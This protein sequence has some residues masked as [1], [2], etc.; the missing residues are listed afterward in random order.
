MPAPIHV[1]DSHT[2]GEP[3]RV[4]IE[5]MPPILGEDM[6]AVRATL[7]SDHDLLRKS[8]VGEPRSSDVVVGAYLWPPT[9]DDR[10]WRVVFFNNVGYL[11][12]CGHGTIGVVETLRHRRLVD[13][14]RVDLVTPVGPVTT[15]LHPD[16]Q[17]SFVNVPCRRSG[18]GVTVEVPGYGVVRGDVAWGGN[19]FF[20]IGD[21]PI[22]VAKEHI[23]ELQA[24]T[25][26]VRKVLGETGVTGDDGGE[27]DHVEVFGPS[28]SAHSRNYVLCPGLEHDRS[29]C[30]TGTSAKIACLAAD[31]K[32]APGQ[33]WTQE[34]IIGSIF[35]ATYH[36]IDGQVVPTVTGR[37]HVVGEGV[38]VVDEE[39]PFRW[40]VS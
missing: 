32:L 27:I 17:V 40:G 22:P 4:V 37:A 34:S 15:W 21:P 1:I 38:L 2:G 31:G 30:G 7:A 20:L 33:V 35:E 19:W 23:P 10:P 29:P 3:T 25:M 28:E 5:G 9:G 12:M 14:G 8:I 11:N 16:G 26:A 18:A 6:A 39:D 13:L 36:L 24:F